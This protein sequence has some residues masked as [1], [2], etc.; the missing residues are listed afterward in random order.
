MFFNFKID[1]RTNINHRL[2]TDALSKHPSLYPLSPLRLALIIPFHNFFKVIETGLKLINFDSMI[3]KQHNKTSHSSIL[4]SIQWIVHINMVL[5]TLPRIYR[6]TI[7]VESH[8]VFAWLLG[9]IL[10]PSGE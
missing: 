8:N 1:F 6:T 4:Y 2:I 9:Q 3:K 5:P 7:S 10:W